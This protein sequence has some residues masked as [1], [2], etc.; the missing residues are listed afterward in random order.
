MGDDLWIDGPDDIA[1]AP[2]LKRQRKRRRELDGTY[3]KIPHDRGLKLAKQAGSPVL[4]VLLALEHAI[5]KTRNNRVR[6]TNGLLERYGISRQS[7]VRGLRQLTTAE[8]I[9]VERG[10]GRYG[11]PAV[12]HHWYTRHGKLKGVRR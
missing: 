3:A 4:A 12:T 9:S 8:V 6:L 5:H 11:A 10:R 2:D 7:K 1:N